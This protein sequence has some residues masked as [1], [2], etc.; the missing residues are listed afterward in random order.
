MT[1]CRSWP[2]ESG[3]QLCGALTHHPSNSRMG[4][5][6]LDPMG[7][8]TRN[9]RLFLRR[10]VTEETRNLDSSTSSSLSYCVSIGK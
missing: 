7:K 1:S 4:K 6:E 8:L 9:H 3:W 5:E 10:K 2:Y